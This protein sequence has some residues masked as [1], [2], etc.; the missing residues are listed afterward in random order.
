[1]GCSGTAVIFT[2]TSSSQLRFIIPASIL[3]ICLCIISITNSFLFVVRN[4]LEWKFGLLIVQRIV[5]SYAVFAF[6]FCWPFHELLSRSRDIKFV[7]LLNVSRIINTRIKLE[8]Y[9]GVDT[10]SCNFFFLILIMWVH[11]L[12][13]PVSFRNV[14]YFCICCLLCSYLRI[15]NETERC[16]PVLFACLWSWFSL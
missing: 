16:Y 12:F 3:R 10:D 1:M 4:F 2:F 11:C 15:A 5:V 6:I 14:L 13:G 8:N 9:C 7:T